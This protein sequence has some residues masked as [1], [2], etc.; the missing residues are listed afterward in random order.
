VTLSVKRSG[1]SKQVKVTLA[2]RPART[3]NGG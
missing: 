3:P 1:Q 2:D